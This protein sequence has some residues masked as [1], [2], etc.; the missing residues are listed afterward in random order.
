MDAGEGHVCQ[1]AGIMSEDEAIVQH[2]LLWNLVKFLSLNLR[3]HH[4]Q[5][6]RPKVLTQVVKIMDSWMKTSW[7][8]G[9][10]HLYVYDDHDNGAN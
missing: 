7:P 8:E 10:A 9:I 6:Y 2:N 4:S 1:I 3:F 5:I